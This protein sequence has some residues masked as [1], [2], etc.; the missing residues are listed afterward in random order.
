MID[1]ILSGCI[2]VF[3]WTEHDYESYLFHHTHAW[4]RN[5]TINLGPI[6]LPEGSALTGQVRRALEPCVA[7][8]RRCFFSSLQTTALDALLLC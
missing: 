7:W 8:D 6:R 1:S 2:P 4:K 5:A 3:F